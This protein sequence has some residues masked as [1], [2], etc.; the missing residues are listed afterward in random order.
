MCREN[1]GGNKTIMS[2][3]REFCRLSNGVKPED[4]IG[5]DHEALG[6]CLAIVARTVLAVRREFLA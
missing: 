4:L 6:F 5:A 3:I 1:E 2:L